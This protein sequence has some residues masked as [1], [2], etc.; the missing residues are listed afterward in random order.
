MRNRTVCRHLQTQI[1]QSWS[2]CPCLCH[3]L[4]SVSGW[5]LGL[6]TPAGAD[7]PLWTGR[8]AH[9]HRWSH[10]RSNLWRKMKMNGLVSTSCIFPTSAKR[11]GCNWVTLQFNSLKKLWNLNYKEKKKVRKCSL[12]SL[13]SKNDQRQTLRKLRKTAFY[14]ICACKI[15]HFGNMKTSHGY[16]LSSFKTST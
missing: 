10:C 1:H 4:P 16:V 5:S 14:C 12:N 6:C 3:P 8:G 9:S 13:T 7:W 2:C 15:K 11:F